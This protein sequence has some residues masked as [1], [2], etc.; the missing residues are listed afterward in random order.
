MS[1]HVTSDIRMAVA[2]PDKRVL[3]HT[4]ALNAIQACQKGGKIHATGHVFVGS[5]GVRIVT[6]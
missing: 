6:L 5:M 2:K 4:R 1:T 3:R